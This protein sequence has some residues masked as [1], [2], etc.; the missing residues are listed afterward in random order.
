[1][2]SYAGHARVAMAY[3]YDAEKCARL[4]HV[5]VF[6]EIN[7]FGSEIRKLNKSKKKHKTNSNKRGKKLILFL[8]QNAILRKLLNY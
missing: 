4:G 7:N 6:L 5:A 1:M 3:G 2:V 8:I